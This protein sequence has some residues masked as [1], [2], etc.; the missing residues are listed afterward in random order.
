M[1]RAWQPHAEMEPE[2]LLVTAADAGGRHAL[3]IRS[4]GSGT[5]RLSLLKLTDFA[6]PFRH[7]VGRTGR[8]PSV[9]GGSSYLDTSM[10]GKPIVW[11]NGQVTYFPA[12]VR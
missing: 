3:R 12:W 9:G 11:A 4:T 2:P 7:G 1:S 10:K 5:S 6:G 8:R